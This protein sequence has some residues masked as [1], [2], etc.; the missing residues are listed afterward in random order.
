MA[1]SSSNPSDLVS[2]IST[3]ANST[4][5]P[6]EDAILS[7]LQVRFRSE[8]HYTRVGP[9]TLVAVNP[10]RT[11]ANLNDA[12]ADA[13]LKQTYMEVDWEKRASPHPEEALPPHPYEMALRAYHMMRRTHAS[14]AIVY[15]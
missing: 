7:V 8:Q 6:S 2:L 14:Q 12:S 1:S 15:R 11:L 9:T 10:L 3:N 4:V 13:Y 5:F